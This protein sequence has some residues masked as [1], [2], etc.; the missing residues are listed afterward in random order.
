MSKHDTQK[1]HTTL[2]GPAPINQI[3]IVTEVHRKKVTLNKRHSDKK[4]YSTSNVK[5]KRRKP[6]SLEK[7]SHICAPSKAH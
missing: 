3:S 5:I 7:G 1:L 6:P 2:L 4:N